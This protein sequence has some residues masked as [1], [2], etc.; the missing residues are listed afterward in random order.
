[1][2]CHDQV[3]H[4]IASKLKE[5]FK[6]DTSICVYADLQ[7]WRSSES[8]QATIPSAL[9]STPFR[10]D[11]V[12]YNSATSSVAL[13]E[14]TCPLDSEHHILSA[15]SRKQSKPDYLQLLAEFDRLQISNYYETMEISVLGHYQLSSIQ[16]IKKF[17]DFIQPSV[18]TKS[19]IRQI[20]DSAARISVTCSHR[21]FMARNCCVWLTDSLT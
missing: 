15:R 18:V 5:L 11:I 19:I 12:V 10:P 20:L 3:L 8:P 14:L 7:G 1:M 21:I 13:L 16:N 4:L 6:F 9:V 17:T 2:H